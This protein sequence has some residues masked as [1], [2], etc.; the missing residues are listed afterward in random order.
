MGIRLKI[1]KAIFIVANVYSRNAISDSGLDM[2]KWLINDVNRAKSK[3]DIG[4]AIAVIAVSLSLFSKLYSLIGTGLLQPNLK[5][6]IDIAPIGSICFKGFRVSLPSAFAVASPSLKAVYAWAY[7]CTVEAISIEGTAINDHCINSCIDENIDI[8][9]LI[10]TN[11]F[12]NII[13]LTNL[14]LL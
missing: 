5:S 2:K 13:L 12:D 11:L 9:C 4:P 3:F 8:I 7:S 14:Q 1:A 10:N 6:I